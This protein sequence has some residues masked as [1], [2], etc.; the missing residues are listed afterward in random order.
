MD[1]Q[2]GAFQ[3]FSGAM[4]ERQAVCTVHGP[5]TERGAQ[6][7]TTS[8]VRWLGCSQ[9]NKAVE[10]AEKAE[11]RRK[12]EEARQARIEA[13]LQRAGIP[14]AFRDRTL[15]NY[16]AETDEQRYALGV[17]R[18][19]SANF[20]TKCHPRGEWLVFAGERGT[21]KSHLAI[22][23]AAAAMA[24]GTAMYI[25]AADMIRRVRATWRKD[26]TESETQVLEMF[27]RDLDLLIVDEIGVQRG[28][29]DEQNTMFDIL[30]MRYAEG[31]PTILLTNLNGAAFS[32]FIGPRLMDR[33]RERAVFVPFKWKS[34]RGTSGQ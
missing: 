3:R 28:T 9:C 14:R 21:G 16:L 22:A 13:R 2:E 12:E 26:S 20:W 18:D 31:R 34:Y 29:E 27:G 32:E 6:L 4:H 24:R 8:P 17:A 30:D 25:R 15:D 5:H 7:L 10:L 19:F 1:E 33:L 23:T 11:A